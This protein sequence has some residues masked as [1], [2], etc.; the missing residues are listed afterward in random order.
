MMTFEEFFKKKKIDLAQLAKAEPALFA[1]FEA[2]YAAMGEKSFDHT[3][4][5]WFN[6][7][8]LKYHTPEEAKV[9]KVVIENPIAEQTVIE[10]LGEGVSAVPA[11]KLGFK[12]KFKAPAPVAANPTPVLPEV[13]KTIEASETASAPKLG[14]KPKFKAPAPVVTESTPIPPETEKPVEPTETAPAP[15]LGFKPKFKAASPPKQKGE[16]E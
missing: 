14:F 11:P 6:Q 2:H 1:E 13:D 9:E 7:L 12:P 10:S 8:R 15:K 16:G 5:Y 4:K 3:K